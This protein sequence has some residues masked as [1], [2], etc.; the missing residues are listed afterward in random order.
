MQNS[1]GTVGL[2][3]VYNAAYLHDNLA[4]KFSRIAGMGDGDA[5]LGHHPRRRQRRPDGHAG[6]NGHGPGRA[7][8]PGAHPQQRHRESR[9]AGAPDDERPG[10]HRRA[11]RTSCPRCWPSR[12][13]CRT[14]STP[15]RTSSFAL[16]ARGLVD[17]R[18]YDVRGALIGPWLRANSTPGTTTT[19]GKAV[20]TRA[21]RSRPACTSTV[22]V[23]PRVT[24]PGA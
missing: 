9:G 17:L 16:P 23:R 11:S 1:T 5:D 3:V 14:R 24:S 8:R 15:A 4:I 10:L 18:V 20:R 7:H 19:C 13:T 6:R 22:C 12:R 21:S 2:Q